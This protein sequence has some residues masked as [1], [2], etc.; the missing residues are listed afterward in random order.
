MSRF[1]VVGFIFGGMRYIGGAVRWRA[2]YFRCRSVKCCV[3][4]MSYNSSAILVRT[5]HMGHLPPAA[6]YV[7]LLPSVF[8]SLAGWLLGFLGYLRKEKVPRE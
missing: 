4:A 1:G 8:K 6:T 5:R 3:F 2:V 7:L